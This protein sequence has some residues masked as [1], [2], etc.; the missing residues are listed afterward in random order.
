M[1][2][3]LPGDRGVGLASGRRQHNLGPQ[4]VAVLAA[5]RPGAGN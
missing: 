3:R 2:T 4:P 5:H 1:H